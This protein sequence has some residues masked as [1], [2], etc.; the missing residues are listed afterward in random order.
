MIIRWFKKMGAF[1]VGVLVGT[2]YGSVVASFT[3][4]FLLTGM[5]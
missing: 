2:V 1:G 5:S 3:A 4:F